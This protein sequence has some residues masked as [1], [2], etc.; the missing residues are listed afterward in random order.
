MTSIPSRMAARFAAFTVRDNR[1][2]PPRRKVGGGL[3]ARG[4]CRKMSASQQALARRCGRGLACAR[5]HDS[6]RRQAI[7]AAIFSPA[8]AGA[9]GRSFHLANAAAWRMRRIW[10]ELADWDEIRWLFNCALWGLTMF[11]S[12]RVRRANRGICSMLRCGIAVTRIKS[13]AG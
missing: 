11:R 7:N 5:D 13:G 1:S 8:V 3:R 6:W 4:I 2:T 12:G 10:L 9:V